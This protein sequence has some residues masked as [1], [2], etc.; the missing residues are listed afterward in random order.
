MCEKGDVYISGNKALTFFLFLLPLTG[1]LAENEPI[2]TAAASSEVF[3]LLTDES[4]LDWDRAYLLTGLI[5]APATQQFRT[6]DPRTRKLPLQP[7]EY[8]RN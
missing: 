4:L 5:K 8:K 2:S 3:L 7:K 1:G 6:M